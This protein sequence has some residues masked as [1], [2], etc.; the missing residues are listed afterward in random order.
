M[1]T[2]EC[3]HGKCRGTDRWLPIYR[4]PSGVS[5]ARGQKKSGRSHRGVGGGGGRGGCVGTRD[6]DNCCEYNKKRGVSWC[7]VQTW[8]VGLTRGRAHLTPSCDRRP[9]PR[10]HVRWRAPFGPRASA[11]IYKVAL[12][13][14]YVFTF[15]FMKTL[16]AARRESLIRAREIRVNWTS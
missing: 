4:D 11:S 5:A 1:E 3:M 9:P 6:A 16:L 12:S 10:A 15:H 7:E 2:N 13:V 14:Q 8:S